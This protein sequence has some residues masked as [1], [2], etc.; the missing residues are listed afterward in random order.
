MPDEPAELIGSTEAL[1]I[2][3]IDRSTLSRW[4][5]FGKLTPVTRLSAGGAFVFDAADIRALAA[6]LASEA[7]AKPAG[8]SAVSA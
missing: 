4:V 8:G 6:R 1:D 3:G 2:L 5:A 7:E